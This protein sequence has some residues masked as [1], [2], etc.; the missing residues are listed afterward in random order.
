MAAA[1]DPIAQESARRVEAAVL[2]L[3]GVA[4]LSSGE[5]SEVALLYPGARVRGLR[6]S[7]SGSVPRLEVHV[8]ADLRTAG[9]LY[10]LSERVRA[11][12]AA[13]VRFPVDVIVADA[14]GD[15]A[16]PSPRRVQ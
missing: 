15:P 7:R 2:A 16:S 1:E 8:V 3:P 6:L 9:D 11:A 4:G 13:H 12:A 5:L 10:E 14:V